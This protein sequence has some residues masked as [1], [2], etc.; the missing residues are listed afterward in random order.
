LT[1]NGA[2][3]S[4]PVV[5]PGAYTMSTGYADAAGRSVDFTALIQACGQQRDGNS[6]GVT[7]ACLAQKGFQFTQVYQP[8]GRYWPLQWIEFGVFG[9]AAVL[10][11]GVAMWWT[12][13][14]IS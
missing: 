10:L 1:V 5:E 11:L 3:G 12:T 2:F 8:G 6:I 9:V 14:R 7:P 13:R 4:T